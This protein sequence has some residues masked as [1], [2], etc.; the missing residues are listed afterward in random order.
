MELVKWIRTPEEEPGRFI[1]AKAHSYI[2]II[3]PVGSYCRQAHLVRFPLTARAKSLV[4]C[5]R[6]ATQ[7]VTWTQ[8]TTL[9]SPL[10]HTPVS[11]QF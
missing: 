9:G 3:N 1:R 2:L 6:L 4:V 7:E 11:E 5:G 8:D 10:H